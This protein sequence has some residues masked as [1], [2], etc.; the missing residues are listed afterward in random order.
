MGKDGM[1]ISDG[2]NTSSQLPLLSMKQAFQMSSLDHSL[3][4]ISKKVSGYSKVIH[5]KIAC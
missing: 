2:A 1:N 5:L 4:T 3:L